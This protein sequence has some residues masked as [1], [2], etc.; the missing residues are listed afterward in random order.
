[1]L[2]RGPAAVLALVLAATST[3]AASSRTL[4][5]G[6]VKRTYLLH[7]PSPRPPGTLPLVI[8]LHG[9]G[10]HGKGMVRLTRGE[11]DALADREGFLVA[12]P[13]GSTSGGT[14]AA[15]PRYRERTGRIRTMSAFLRHSSTGSARRKTPTPP[16]STPPGSRT[17]G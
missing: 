12:Y 11:L 1:M 2:L 10:G 5:V 3:V 13:D 7:V 9:G 15:G 14:T 4:T 17:A 16:A 6:A 8:I